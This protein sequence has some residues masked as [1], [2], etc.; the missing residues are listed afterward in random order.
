MNTSVCEK[1][2]NSSSMQDGRVSQGPK[3]VWLHYLPV[4]EP[5]G[6]ELKPKAGVEGAPKALLPPPKGAEGVAPKPPPK[7]GADWGAPKAG[8]LVAPNAGCTLQV[9]FRLVSCLMVQAHNQ[10]SRIG[11]RA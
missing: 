10:K 6:A 9:G 4:L 3:S 1:S 2:C 7:A 11:H 8:L 5:K